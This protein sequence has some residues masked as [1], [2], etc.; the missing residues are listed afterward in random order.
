M[1]KLTGKRVWITG[2]GTGIG[3]AS[4]L[5]LA[6]SGAEVFVSG[7]RMEP[8]Q[9]VVD[10]ITA[11]GGTA[12]ALPLD[13]TDADAVQAAADEIGQVDILVASAGLNIPTR[14]LDT[15]SA[16]DWEFVVDVNLNGVFYPCHA[17]L[18]GMRERGDGQLILISSWAGRY[19]SR[20]TGAAYNTTKR[21]LIALNESINDESGAFGIRSTV[22]MP[23]E[24]VTPILDKRPKPVSDD[25]KARMLQAEDL[26]ETVRFVAEMP[27]RACI[28]EVLISPTWNRF[29][30]GL[31]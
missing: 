16:K 30:Q 2:G 13:V 21:A 20:M 15:V 19:G 22:I 11:Q 31:D 12:H 1:A 25:Q 17:L 10:K 6:Q 18:P 23:G 4:A 5:A 29:Y 27:P 3:E 8:L 14:A 9:A 26:G 28:N 24:V 7:R